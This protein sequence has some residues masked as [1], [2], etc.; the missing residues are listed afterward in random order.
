MS[1][2]AQLALSRQKLRQAVAAGARPLAMSG[3]EDLVDEAAADLD[4]VEGHVAAAAQRLIQLQVWHCSRH[5][6]GLVHWLTELLYPSLTLD[7]CN[8][9]D[10]PGMCTPHGNVEAGSCVCRHRINS[11]GVAQLW[12]LLCSAG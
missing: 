6:S 11:K 4:K 1:A 7:I 5:W 9:P 3:W 12:V 8:V 10:R 2:E